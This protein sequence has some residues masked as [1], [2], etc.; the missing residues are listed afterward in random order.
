MR[1]FASVSQFFLSNNCERGRSLLLG[2]PA[3]IT[4]ASGGKRSGFSFR[5]LRSGRS[6]AMKPASA[7]FAQAS[8]LAGSPF[9]RL[10]IASRQSI[11]FYLGFLPGL[12]N[13]FPH[14]V[15]GLVSDR[16]AQFPSH[17][18]L[19]PRMRTH[20]RVVVTKLRF[21]VTRSLVGTVIGASRGHT[22]SSSRRRQNRD[23]PH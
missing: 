8:C 11:G 19:I 16:L 23:R 5:R 9:T 4:G 12:A 21:T 3:L 15:P 17:V 6:T 1:V 2:S 14:Q 7:A 13:A 20:A 18:N 10:R 22:A